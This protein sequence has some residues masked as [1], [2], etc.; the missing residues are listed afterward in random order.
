[1]KRML[2]NI[3]YTTPLPGGI[4]LAI[5]LAVALGAGKHLF[6]YASRNSPGCL[7]VALDI[8]L[9]RRSTTALSTALCCWVPV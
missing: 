5:A 7:F 1:M 9:R 8:G 4:P 3:G 2:C 6:R